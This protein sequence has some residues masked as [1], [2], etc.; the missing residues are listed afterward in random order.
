MI[1]KLKPKL[2]P[3]AQALRAPLKP[4]RGDTLVE[5]VFALA[6]LTLVLTGSIGITVKAFQQGQTARERTQLTDEAQQQMEVLRA[7]RDNHTW[8]EFLNGGTG[9]LGVINAQGGSCVITN[10]CIHLKLA[11]SVL[12]TEYQPVAGGTQG[13]VPTSYMEIAVEP[14]AGSP[15]EIVDF[16]LSYGFENIGG[17]KANIGHI[18]TRLTNIR[19]APPGP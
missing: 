10:S 16:T 19:L 5:V 2:T 4:E 9:Y 11:N 1:F 15:T 13:S 3:L 6:I 14:V 18:K 17:G 7:F 12:L 8:A